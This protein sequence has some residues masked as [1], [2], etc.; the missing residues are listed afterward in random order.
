MPLDI[1]HKVE[2]FE[3]AAEERKGVWLLVLPVLRSRYFL[4]SLAFYLVL[5][6]IFAGYK[7]S[8]YLI[9]P[10]L[11]EGV[12]I[13]PPS[14]PPTPPMPKQE[15]KAETKEV[16]VTVSAATVKSPVTRITVDMPTEFARPEQLNVR[17][18]TVMTDVKVRTDMSKNIEVAKIARLKGVRA[19]QKDW[20][21]SGDGRRTMAKFTIFLAKYQ[22]GDWYCNADS[23]VGGPCYKG[24]G[25]LQNLMRQI[26]QWSRN[27]IDAQITPEVLDVGTDKLFTIKP[28]F[29]YLT[30]HKD[31]HLLENEVRN[32]RDYLNVGGC[33]WGDSALVGRRSR[34]DIA[35]RREMKRV[36]P[37]RDFEIVPEKHEMF[38]T[39]FENIGLPTGMNFSREPIEMINI[40]GHLAVL[41]TPNG[42]GHLWEARLDQNGMIEYRRV[43]LTERG[44]LKKKAVG[45]GVPNWWYVYGPHLYVPRSESSAIYRNANNDEAARNAY[46]FGINVVVHLLTRYQ[47]EFRLLPKDLPSGSSAAQRSTE[48]AGA[49][50]SAAE[51]PKIVNDP[52]APPVT[53]KPE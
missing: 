38:D 43:N 23:T 47:K 27:R 18:V 1:E 31:F 17:P 36:L 35:F 49:P 5:L 53:S 52:G 33:I 9:P 22:D 10:P 26:R 14:M 12:F 34:F 7:I 20:E 39:F 32:L 4:M 28:P 30:G 29:V 11:P 19:F 13:L 6:L 25:S 24:C 44:K 42:Y 48:G 46:K 40:G 50:S 15:T 51:A 3:H 16:K 41:Y 37:D 45:D 21:V 2:E 8:A